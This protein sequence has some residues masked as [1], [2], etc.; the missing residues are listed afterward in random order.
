MLSAARSMRASEGG[1]GLDL[2]PPGERRVVTLPFAVK[3]YEV[4]FGGVVSNI[5]YIRWLEDLRLAMMAAVYPIAR[6]IAEDVAPLLAATRIAYDR[7][8]T[9]A[10]AVVGRMWVTAMARVRWS[11]AAEFMVGATRH[12]AAEQD[13]LFIRL[14]T[15]RPVAPPLALRQHYAP[16]TLP[17]AHAELLAIRAAAAGRGAARLDGCDLYVTL[18]P[19]AMC[20]AAISFARVRRLYFGAGDPKG[21]AV[22]H[23]VRFFAQPTCHHRPEIYGG[24]DAARAAALLKRFFAARR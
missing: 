4:D 8:V 23:G 5:V 12:A 22:E 10:D 11:V 3:T 24:I 6:A 2:S 19:C 9:I 7:P 16:D 15:H 21:G 13:G 1:S 20:A 14:S 18:E 17:A